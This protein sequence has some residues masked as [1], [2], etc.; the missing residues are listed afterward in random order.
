[1]SNQAHDFPLVNCYVFS[2]HR[3]IGVSECRRAVRRYTDTPTLRHS[4]SSRSPRPQRPLHLGF[5]I[6]QEIGAG[7]DALAFFEAASNLVI[8]AEFSAQLDKAR[9]EFA[10][11]LIH[12]SDV[13]LP[14]GDH[15][16]EG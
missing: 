16:A 5:G 13:A 14:G 1:M 10:F 11:A 4:V 6:N 2:L 15:R 9:L 3:G 8:V 12:E 7:D